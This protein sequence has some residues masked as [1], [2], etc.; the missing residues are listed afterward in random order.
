L[1]EGT[2]PALV[3]Q[4]RRPVVVR[5]AN[6]DGG[7]QQRGNHR[8]NDPEITRG[9]IRIPEV[10]LGAEVEQAGEQVRDVHDPFIPKE[11]SPLT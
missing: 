3:P 10:G 4:V 6:R 2:T 7:D 1:L 9:G 11:E 8:E 5:R